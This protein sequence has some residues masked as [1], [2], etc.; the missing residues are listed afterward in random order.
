MSKE[1]VIYREHKKELV[2]K[3]YSE[4]VVIELLGDGN[5]I[6]VFKSGNVKVNIAAAMP[7]TWIT[8]DGM[9]YLI[10]AFSLAAELEIKFR[11][12]FQAAL[13]DDYHNTGG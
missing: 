5:F 2:V 7:G 3:D 9:Q 13:I 1:Q 11:T 10:R 8:Q 6:K 12:E 4:Y